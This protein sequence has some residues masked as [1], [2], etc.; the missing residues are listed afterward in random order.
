M[1]EE[2]FE[3]SW[4]RGIELIRKS[5]NKEEIIRRLHKALREMHVKGY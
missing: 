2:S 3:E 5:P 1:R 4:K